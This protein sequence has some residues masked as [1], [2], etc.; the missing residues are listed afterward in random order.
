MTETFL[1]RYLDIVIPKP[2]DPEVC[3]F[4]GRIVSLIPHFFDARNSR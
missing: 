1:P 2:S 3:R 4:M